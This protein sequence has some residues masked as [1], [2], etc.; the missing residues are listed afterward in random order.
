M[1]TEVSR[2]LFSSLPFFETNM[3]ALSSEIW[4]MNVGVFTLESPWRRLSNPVPCVSP[5]ILLKSFT[6][7]KSDHRSNLKNQH[8]FSSVVSGNPQNFLKKKL[9]LFFW[10]QSC[11]YGRAYKQPVRKWPANKE[12]FQ[13]LDKDYLLCVNQASQSMR[14]VRMSTSSAGIY[15]VRARLARRHCMSK[16]SA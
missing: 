5:I 6:S 2:S 9:L 15:P 4:V 7:R 8:T 16:K 14:P 13:N 11:L 3:A 12:Y 1:A 10:N